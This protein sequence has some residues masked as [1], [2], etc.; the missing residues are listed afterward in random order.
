MTD[1]MYL[2]L[3]LENKMFVSNWIFLIVAFEASVEFRREDI[4][5]FGE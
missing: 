1:D 2:S 5:F 4:E 3:L